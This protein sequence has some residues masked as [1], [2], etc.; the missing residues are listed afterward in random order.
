MNLIHVFLFVV[1]L[2][3]VSLVASLLAVWFSLRT[4]ILS[5]R[6]RCDIYGQ[7]IDRH[8]VIRDKLCIDKLGYLRAGNYHLF[9]EQNLGFCGEFCPYFRL[10]LKNGIKGSSFNC[11][12][13]DAEILCPEHFVD[14]RNP[15]KP[16]QTHERNDE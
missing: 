2:S 8:A 5:R 15:D 7:R 12:F 13:Q 6:S 1:A 4:Y 3:G 14:L 10:S 16:T 9:C 11:H